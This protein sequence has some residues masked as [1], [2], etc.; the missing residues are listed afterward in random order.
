[1]EETNKS[2]YERA[3]ELADACTAIKENG[4]YE[5]LAREYGIGVR[6][7]GDRF[8]S[9][10][11]KCV[12]DYI[13]EKN[14]P[15]KEQMVDAIIKCDSSDEVKQYLGVNPYWLTGIYDKY[16]GVS[17]F[18]KSK[19]KLL[20][21]KEVVPY[22]PSVEDNLSILLSQKLGDGAFETYDGRSSIKL[23]HG[24]KQFDYLKMKVNL[25]CKAFPGIPTGIGNIR[26][27]V[28]SSGYT[29]YVWRTKNFRCKAMDKAIEMSLVDAVHSLT[30]FGWCLWYLD[31]GNL[32]QSYGVH[33]LSIAI[34]EDDVKRAAVDEL[35]TYGFNFAMQ[36]ECIIISDHIAIAKF[37]NCFVKPFINLIPESM[38]Y[39]CDVKI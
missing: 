9:L 18:A 37:I 23:E 39:K 35:K 17:T 10:F 20:A 30:P 22:N 21:E 14:T 8:K 24:E 32:A 28:Q 11:G 19:V 26:K 12:R 1:M 31:D 6:T 25:L 4:V 16:F 13:S 33:H 27:R 34:N 2:F 5:T 38:L 15:T 7:A 36:K 29:S 3:K